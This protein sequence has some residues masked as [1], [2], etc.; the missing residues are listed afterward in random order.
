MNQI[1]ISQS[2]RLRIG[3]GILTIF[4]GLPFLAGGLLIWWAGLR[5]IGLAV[6][7]GQYLAEPLLFGKHLF[8]LFCGYL[9]FGA[10]ALMTGGGVYCWV[11]QERRRITALN[12][13]GFVSWVRRCEFDEVVQVVQHTVSSRPL[14]RRAQRNDDVSRYYSSYR[15]EL[16]LT[17][18]R[19]MMIGSSSDK[20]RLLAKAERIAAQLGVPMRNLGL[21]GR[22]YHKTPTP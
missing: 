17:D 9:F 12:F 5:D 14:S 21:V 6:L 20:E 8:V 15:L 19:R 1:E 10:G 2:M 4:L 3:Q 7:N 11:D 22:A 13:Y 16:E 18:G